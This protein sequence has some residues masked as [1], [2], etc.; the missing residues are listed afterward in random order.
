MANIREVREGPQPQGVD[1]AITYSLNTVNW[2]G[3]P[4]SPTM[5]VY[6]LIDGAYADVTA[7]VA[8]VGSPTVT[9]DVI[10]LPEIRSLVDGVTYRVEV[11]FSV[12]GGAPV[13]AYFWI[14]AER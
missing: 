9:D 12:D 1:E 4:T 3:S 14:E 11:K 7:T 2:G 10:A 13:E 6:S 5:K 8:P